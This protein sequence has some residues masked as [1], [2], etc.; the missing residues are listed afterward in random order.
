MRDFICL[1]HI[2]FRGGCVDNRFLDQGKEGV[3]DTLRVDISS[4]CPRGQRFEARLQ[5]GRDGKKWMD[6]KDN[7]EVKSTQLVNN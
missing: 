5:Q 4:L 7:W 1:L 3:R 6:L 2:S